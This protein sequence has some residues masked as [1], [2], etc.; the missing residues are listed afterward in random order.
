MNARTAEKLISSG[1]LGT[2]ELLEVAR[3]SG[4]WSSIMDKI[5][6][7]DMDAPEVI[8]LGRRFNSL[9]LWRVLIVTCRL[10]TD[11]LMNIAESVNE[12]GVGRLVAE[13]VDFSQLTIP[14]LLMLGNLAT[15]GRNDDSVWSR[16]LAEIENR[17][18]VDKQSV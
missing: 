10:G 17:S 6:A 3:Q 11:S 1:L 16:V 5:G 7:S 13:R 12:H 2:K 15:S 4:S 8:K 18:S 9:E 14:Q